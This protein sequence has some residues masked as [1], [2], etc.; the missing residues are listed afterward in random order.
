[1]SYRVLLHS[2]IGGVIM[3]DTYII[4][5]KKIVTVS[6]KGTIENG[7]MIVQDGKIAGIIERNFSKKLYPTIPVLDYT[8]YVI[9][10]SL[11]DCHTHL[12]EFA[13]NSLYPV[14]KET[15]LHAGRA[16]LMKVLMA[17]ITAIGEQVCG[18]PQSAFS[19]D[20]YRAACA[21]LP[22]DISF[23]AT[24]ISI[25][26]EELAHFTSITQSRAVCKADLIN[27]YI[28]HQMAKNS[29]YPGENLFLN[30]TPANFT[31][32]VV[33]RAGE[34]I[35]TRKELQQIV[36]TFHH[37]KKQIGVHVAGEEGI[38]MAL[39]TGVD[40]LHHAHGITKEQ[41]EKASRLGV[42]VIAT[43][44]G[45]THLKPNSPEDVVELMDDEIE[46]SIATDAYLPPY[47]NVDWLPFEAGGLQGPDV[48][49]KISNPSMKLLKEKGYN[50]NDILALITAN[51]AKVLGKGNR[52]GK[53]QRGMDANFIVAEG[54]P[55][56]EMVEV[57]GIR[58]VFF[59]GKMVVERG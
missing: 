58:K 38:D 24:S 7:A 33:P 37:V 57:E 55:G 59:R 23:A 41:L 36:R 15:Q 16:I 47:P 21:G 9:T 45:G 53:L 1:M 26:F 6:E 2:V 28:I 14:T 39:D 19:I 11:V 3:K 25:G 12:L 54:I 5:A 56:L 52:F 31:A 48:L 17:G 10:P 4:H 18:H 8:D 44:L 51:P 30:A 22:I 13:P 40:V 46:T 43:P 20:D 34:L 32:E 42:K 29:D 49:M 27:A 35:Y 50:E